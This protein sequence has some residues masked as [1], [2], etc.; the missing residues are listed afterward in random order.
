MFVS[1]IPRDDEAISVHSTPLWN[2][3][4]PPPAAAFTSERSF[5]CDTAPERSR[6][7]LLIEK[8]PLAMS[9]PLPNV[10]VAVEP[11]FSVF[12]DSP[13]DIVDVPIPSTEMI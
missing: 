13:P 11:T 2:M 4:L 8:H 7:L 5:S 12:T 3:M 6:Q 9:T 1:A 10:D